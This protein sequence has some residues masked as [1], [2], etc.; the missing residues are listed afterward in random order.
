MQ[1]KCG[2]WHVDCYKVRVYTSIIMQHQSLLF[3][4]LGRASRWG[5]TLGICVLLASCGSTGDDAPQ[6]PPS[7]GGG[8]TDACRNAG[9]ACPTDGQTVSYSASVA[10]VFSARCTSCHGAGQQNGGVRLDGHSNAQ[11]RG[12][13]AVSAMRRGSMPPSGG[14]VPECEIRAIERWLSQGAPNN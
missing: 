3:G 7:G 9:A 11:A 10:T 1:S 5:L 8:S 2:I 4:V 12:N 14:C 6:P 13:A